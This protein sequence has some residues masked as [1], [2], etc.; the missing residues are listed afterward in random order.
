M[1]IYIIIIIIM[2]AHT[3]KGENVE[4]AEKNHRGEKNR[5]GAE[6]R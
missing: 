3:G 5:S 1:Y 6:D 2:R 4:D